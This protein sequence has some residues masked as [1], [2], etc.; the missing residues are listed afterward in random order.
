MASWLFGKAKDLSSNATSALQS[1]P[2]PTPTSGFLSSILPSSVSSL[3]PSSVSSLL[4]SSVSS[5][6]PESISSKL[7]SLPSLSSFSP[8]SLAKSALSGLKS[9]G[10]TA[11]IGALLA[12]GLY[13]TVGQKLPQKYKDLLWK[14]VSKLLSSVLPVDKFPFLKPLLE[15]GPP[16][17]LLKSLGL[18]KVPGIEKLVSAVKPKLQHPQGTLSALE[19]IKGIAPGILSKLNP[20]NSKLFNKRKIEQ[21]EDDEKYQAGETYGKPEALSTGLKEDL[22]AVG[23]KAAHSDLK[24]LLELLQNKPMDDRKMTLEKVM[25]LTASLPRSSKAREK[26]SG[27]IVNKLWTD[28]QHPPLSYLG[29]KYRFRTPD[30]SYNNPM[31]PD[32]GKAG[33]PYARTVRKI[34]ATHGVPPDPGL[35]FDLFMARTDETF[36]ENPAG[37]SSVL[38][39]HATIIIHDIFR[40]NRF[41]SSISDTSSYLDLA[42]LYGSSLE[43]QLKIRTM[44][45]GFLKPDTFHERRLIGQPPGVNIMLIMYSRFHNY[46]ADVLLKINE[47]G[48]FTLPPTKNE[49]DEKKA[50]AKQDND[51]F[52][53]ARLIVNGMYINISLH[54]YL[55][56]ITNVHH[57]KSDWSI[58]P[59]MEVNKLFDPEGTPRGVGNQVSAEFNLLYRFHPAIS[60]RDEKWLNEFFESIFP[61][62][63]KPLDQL[64][65]EE[66]IQGLFRFEQSIPADP[67]KREFGGLKRGPDGRFNDADLVRV[68]KESMEDPAGLFGAR[69]VPKALKIIEVTG[70][71]TARKWQLGSLNEM[72]Q[73]FKLKRYDTFEDINPDPEIADLLR[74]LYDHPDMVE[75]YPGM[76]IEDI[77]PRMDPGCGI[78]APYTV[79]RAVFSDAVCLVRSDRFL[80]IDYTASNLTSWGINEVNPDL[81]VCGGSMFYKLFHRSLP[82]WFPYNSLHIMQPMYTKKMNEQI[83]TEIGTIDQYSKADPKPPPRKVIVTKHSIVTG[84]LGDQTAFRVPWVTYNELFPGKKDYNG[85]MLA[86]DTPA[87]KAQH[88]LLAEILYT[89]AEFPKLLTDTAVKYGEEFLKKETLS[90]SKELDQIDILRDVAIPLMTRLLADLWSLDLKTPEDPSGSLSIKQIYK[91]L[92]DLREFGFNNT[93]PARTWRKRLSAQDAAKVMTASTLK[94]I[95]RRQSASPVAAASGAASA[96]ATKSK[97]FISKAT[98]SVTGAV[99]GALSKVPVVGKWFGGG[100]GGGDGSAAAKATETMG[101]GSLRWYG[102]QVV[103]ELREAGNTLEETGDL[104]WL[105]AI[106]AVGASVCLF[107]DVLTFFLKEENSHHWAKIQDLASDTTN[108]EIADKTLQQ[109]VLEAGRISGTSAVARAC[110]A[111]KTIDGQEFK[112]GDV[113]V[114]LLG[115]ASNDKDFVP[116]PQKFKL[117]RPDDTYLRWGSGVHMCLGKQISL[118]YVTAL[119]K[120][121]ARLKNLRPAP[122]DMGVLKS[123]TLD[124]G[125]YYLNDSW[126]YLSADPTTWKVHFEGYGKGTH[127]FDPAATAGR[128]LTALY[129]SLVKQDQEGPKGVTPRA[130]IQQ[131]ANGVKPE[132]EK[133][134]SNP[135]ADKKS[136]G[137][138]FDGINAPGE[139][140]KAPG[141]LKHAL[142]S[143]SG[144]K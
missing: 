138:S 64:T 60:K 5:F 134:T 87:H 126:D 131:E 90:L 142:S 72:R 80:T 16:D 91:Y 75:M 43:D 65:P 127:K 144:S 92:V 141:V 39:Y 99:T 133:E 1:Q 24:T 6:L 23:L 38:F 33:S 4:P 54:D 59:R 31:I 125:T 49:E 129:N 18:D 89:P 52:N 35:L 120:L 9:S 116:D 135:P 74:K 110:A 27:V 45:K 41:D 106:A 143:L 40:T 128:N 11:V 86:G 107:A 112:P 67:G 30:G 98:S 76:M 56:G 48:R 57:S 83:A 136:D 139:N 118:S 66:F 21:Q 79:A 97:G 61:E 73:F 50:L 12:Y 36:K 26:L 84:V 25:A 103:K 115:P 47:G 55:R 10:P 37:I 14:Y 85:F 63:T 82:G 58:D 130:E 119:I 3:L 95:E 70:I 102:D 15:K 22:K 44:E 7:P 77:K 46:V 117:D 88:K 81:D 122:G 8:E 51:L 78:G 104:C 121:S 137:W 13:A 113:A 69:M 114:L 93:D 68:M 101:A 111:P 71:L 123:V 28:L 17:D 19:S 34:E 29:D 108:S 140:G 109:Y 32:L 20:L 132:P 42:P 124:T 2:V 53:T 62:N 96:A 100:G 94:C 105:T